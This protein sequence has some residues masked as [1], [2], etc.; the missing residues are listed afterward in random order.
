M[1]NQEPHAVTVRRSCLPEVL[2]VEDMAIALVMTPSGARKVMR[3]GDC[4]PL[5]RI[6]RRLAVTREAFLRAME[7]RSG[8]PGDA[9]GRL[10]LID[11]ESEEDL[12]SGEPLS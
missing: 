2:F 6:G 1:D 8:A 11:R 5:L 7:A 3:R 9:R 12:D 4:G 10:T